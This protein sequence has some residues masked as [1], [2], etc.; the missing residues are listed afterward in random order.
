MSAEETSQI[1][2]WEVTNRFGPFATQSDPAGLFDT[3]KLLKDESFESWHK[4]LSSEGLPSPYYDALKARQHEKMHWNQSASRHQDKILSYVRNE[5]DISTTVAVAAYVPSN[6]QCRWTYRGQEVTQRCDEDFEFQ[7]PISGATVRV[8]FGGREIE[9][10][11]KP[12]H[13]V[14]VGLGDSYAS[15][16]GNPDY[17][18]EWKP[19]QVLPGN[20]ELEW[21]VDYTSRLISP[22]EAL[23][24]K[25]NHWVDDTCHRSFYSHQS[26]TALKVASENKHS[27][28][29]FLHYACTGAEA[30]DGLLAP[31]YQ[32][33]G[34]EG[35]FVPFSQ[36]NFAIRELCQDGKPLVEAAPQY[37]SVS[38]KE[39]AGINIA[40]FHRRGGPGNQPRSRSN[41]IPDPKLDAFSRFT[42]DLRD[43]NGGHFPQSGLLTCATG[44]IRTPDYV[45]LNEGGNS[46]GFADIVQYF[47]VPSRW[48]IEKVGRRLFPEVCPDPAYRVDRRYNKQLHDY[49]EDLDRQLN[50]HAGDLIS[51]ASNSLGMKDRYTL[52]F[53]ILEYRLGIEPRKIVMAQYPDPMRETGSSSPAC[54]PLTSADFEVYGD[55][56]GVFKSQSAWSGLKTVAPK[57]LIR[58]LSN[59]PIGRNFREWHFNLTASEAGNALKQFDDLR[60]IL[61]DT[62]TSRGISFVC[63]TRDAFVGYGWWKG[64]RLNLPNTKPYWA[65][66]DWKP[67]SYD[68]ETRAIRTGND[69]IITQPGEKRITGAIHPNLTGH[70]LIAQEVYDSIWGN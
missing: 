35:V 8:A 56:S 61:A 64:A 54:E 42:K 67:Y 19:N 30:F 60:V 40:F 28:V 25:T 39:T 66:W 24:A 22:P 55:P 38:Q 52:L 14:I 1:I 41:L 65:I 62:A 20:N 47:L 68:G 13:I 63:E 12:R 31:Q 43:Q 18:G 23:G 57:S 45:F 5:D 69:T 9:E 37:E 34:E 70:R 53:N 17:P 59:I 36:V 48:K 46:I 21:L 11:I 2:E 29:S 26:L 50:Y 7:V 51:G 32:A 58:T 33:W 49:C 27:Y 4:R 44:K 6:E 3:Y 10:L 16:E 15:G